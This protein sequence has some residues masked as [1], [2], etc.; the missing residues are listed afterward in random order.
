MD[1]F[2]LSD[3]PQSPAN[4]APL[5]GRWRPIR[6][7]HAKTPEAPPGH[8]RNATIDLFRVIAIF[9]VIV[10]HTDPVTR[11]VFTSAPEHLANLMITGAGR[12]AVPFFFVVSGYFFGRKIRDGAP[13]LPLFTN[14]A[15]R[16]LR[17]WV[18]WSLIYLCLPLRLGQWFHQGWWPAMVQQFRHMAAHPLLIVFVGGKGHLW[19]LMALVMALALAAICEKLRAR[20]V[21]Y[22]L[23]V[24]LYA[25]G[26]LSGLYANTAA[27][28]SMPFDPRNGPVMSALLVACGYWVAGW[29]G[30]I[31]PY[32]AFAVAAI[33]LLGFEA[34]LHWVP[35]LSHA[36][37]PII[38]YGAFTPVF[39]IGALLFGLAVPG[40]GGR[41]W[42]HVGAECVL[43]IYVCHDLFVEPAW[44]LHAYFHSYAWEFAFPVIVFALAMG[45]TLLLLSE[46]H[47][48]WLVR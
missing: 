21:F 3:L 7:W 11:K 48:R 34:E 35:M 44:M 13:P 29:R 39:G 15:K 46:R 30:R 14:Y 31:D 41:W 18:L 32:V 16:L 45:F 43:G 37:P 5:E 27:G 12:L 4:P 20:W 23:A 24:A 8:A 25:C 33:G 42:P 17:I 6:P 10:V 22:A 36:W 26:L 2:N 40:W 47:L 38:D 1:R 19:F 28:F 9:G